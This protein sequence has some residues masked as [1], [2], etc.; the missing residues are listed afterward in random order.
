MK[1]L[2]YRAGIE[3]IALNDEPLEMDADAMVGFATVMLLGFLFGK[4]QEEV[5]RD[6]VKFRKRQLSLEKE[7]RRRAAEA[8]L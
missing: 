8:P 4:E 2:G 6:V 1:R 7:L 5:A 3:M